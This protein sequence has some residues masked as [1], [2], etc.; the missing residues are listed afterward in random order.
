MSLRQSETDF[1]VK[2]VGVIYRFTAP[3][4][5]TYVGKHVCD[6]SGWPDAG[7]GRL[8]DGYG[9][10]GPYI[11]RAHAKY[12]QSMAWG[13]LERVEARAVLGG[14]ER[15]WIV[16]ERHRVGKL[17][18]NVTSGGDG[19]T[20]EDASLLGRMFGH[21]GGTVVV[22]MIATREQTDPEFAKKMHQTRSDNARR[23]IEREKI[24][25]VLAAKCREVRVRNGRK[26]GAMLQ[27]RALRDPAFRE[28]R[29]RLCQANANAVL[30]SGERQCSF[31]GKIGGRIRGRQLAERAGCPGERVMDELLRGPASVSEL[32]TRLSLPE[33]QVRSAITH[34][35]RRHNV[36]RLSDV[37]PSRFAI[38]PGQFTPAAG[39]KHLVL[40]ALRE[41]VASVAALA[42][43][44]GKSHQQVRM[45]IDE[46]R[47]NGIRIRSLGKGHFALSTTTAA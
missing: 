11:R 42:S 9:G 16:H 24:D 13:I 20:S 22:R 23:R 39:I 32:M 8:P 19:F 40:G 21:L 14:R 3:S 30:P 17:C 31:A 12:G 26:N 5:K 41:G 44:L 34:V 37:R 7:T 4:G 25:P 35:G 28:R 33:H 1:G 38:A 43:L 15:Y 2:Y 36:I 18:Q 27:D 47:R 29:Q 45:A 10:S 46:L 6:P